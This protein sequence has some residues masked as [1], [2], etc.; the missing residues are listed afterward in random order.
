VRR[1][2]RTFS[3]GRLRWAKTWTEHIHKHEL[4]W[5][6]PTHHKTFATIEDYFAYVRST[7][8][9]GGDERKAT[10]VGLGKPWDHWTVVQRVGKPRAVFFDSWGF[11]RATGFDYFTF[12]KKRR[13]RVILLD[14]KSRPKKQQDTAKK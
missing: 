8:N 2:S 11:P 5:S 7:L 4:I 13:E 10:I 1:H 9:G 12:D 6:Q 3:E 14:D